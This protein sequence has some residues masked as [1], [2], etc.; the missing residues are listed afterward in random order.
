MSREPQLSNCGALR[1][2]PLEHG[3]L[4]VESILRFAKDHRG[5]AVEHRVRD[6]DVS[7]HGQAVHEVG[8]PSE[9]HEF[10]VD[11]PVRVAIPQGFLADSVFVPRKRPQDFA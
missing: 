11:D 8:A 9:I 10:L 7:T 4:D 3:L 5:L 2:E 6:D 1:V